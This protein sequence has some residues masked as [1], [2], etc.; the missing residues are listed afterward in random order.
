MQVD[1]KIVDKLTELVTEGN[2]LALHGAKHPEAV[3]SWGASCLNIL[4][5]GLGENS[6][7]Y[8]LFKDEFPEFRGNFVLSHVRA[9]LGILNAAKKD[10]EGGFVSESKTT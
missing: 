9:A 4:K 6:E 7:H 3:H 1:Q 10:Y 8:K 2:S 5:N